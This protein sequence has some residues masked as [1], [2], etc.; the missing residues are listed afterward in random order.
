M[1][2]DG[3][4]PARSPIAATARPASGGTRNLLII[5]ATGIFGR[6]LVRHL[7]GEPGLRLFLGARDDARAAGLA[8]EI[9]PHAE[10]TLTPVAVDT[11]RTLGETLARLK[12]WCVVD[13]TGPFQEADHR[14]ARAALEAGAHIVDIAD[15]PGYLG[16]YAEALDACARRAGRAAIGGASSTPALSG[17]VVSHLAEP[18]REVTDIEI[19]IAPGGRGRVGR[20][21]IEAVLSYAGRAVPA[22]RAGKLG[23]LTGWRGAKRIRIDGLGPRRAAPV[24]TADAAL[25]GPRFGVR[26]DIVFRASLESIPEQLGMEVL[27]AL[28]SLWQSMPLR[29]LAAPLLGMRALTRIGTSDTGAMQVTLRGSG[30]DGDEATAH[31]TLIARKGDGPVVPILPAAAAVRALAAGRLGPGARLASEALTLPE[32]VAEMEPYAIEIRTVSAV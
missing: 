6:K 25:L 16:G 17:A 22:W 27:A 9:A 7:S 5:G 2:P 21:V 3:S 26:G 20:A 14:V 12:P 31:W 23:H 10:A 28:R 13:C 32:I 18:M 4:L 1:T 11:R 19:V 15:A 30:P 8:A 29:W 24:E